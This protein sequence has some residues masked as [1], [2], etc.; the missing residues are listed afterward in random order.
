MEDDSLL[1]KEVRK[2][3]TLKNNDDVM[4]L[5]KSLENLGGKI[6]KQLP[7]IDGYLCEFPDENNVALAARNEKDKLEIED[8]L[9]FKL[10]FLSWLPF[11]NP[12]FAFPVKPINKPISK[13]IPS[14]GSSKTGWGINR[15]GAPAVWNKLNKKRV[16]VGIIDTGIDYNHP[17]LANNIKGGI[18]TLDEHHQ[19]MDDYGHGTHV[20]GIIGSS[21]N[22]IGINPYVDIYAVKAFDKKGK[23]NLSDIIEGLD[24][25]LRRQ[26]DVINMSFSTEETNDTFYRVIEKVYASG[27]VMV[28]AAGNDGKKNS[29]NYPARFSHVLAVSATDRNDNL[30]SFSSTGPEINFCAPGLDIPS[31]WIGG[32]YE[33]KS[34][35]S[36]AAPHITGTVV[37]IINYFGSLN[38][39][40]IRN[41]MVQNAVRL[42]KLNGEQQ[43]AGLVEIS[44]IIK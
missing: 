33:E 39:S 9:E 41:I 42:T 23:G 25:L 38:P 11:F 13:P 7:L 19:F 6:I 28:G 10:C 32:G 20:A 34:G 29:V 2:I 5:K 31:A 12:Y 26:V 4:F 15:I 8:D 40:E 37:D 18:S 17:D 30:A 1:K 43:G 14:Q 3:V 35:T 36:F 24:W 44:R 27:I 16:R 22:M 21:G